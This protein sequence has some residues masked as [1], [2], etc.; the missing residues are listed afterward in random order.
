MGLFSK[1]K[2]NKEEKAQAKEENAARLAEFNPTLTIGIEESGVL[3]DGLAEHILVDEAQ[4]AFVVA[5]ASASDFR[6]NNPWIISFDQ[7][8]KAEMHIDEY[9]AENYRYGQRPMRGVGTLT[10]D[11]YKNVFWCYDYVLEMKTSHPYAKR[12]NCRFNGHTLGTKVPS[13]GIFVRR[14]LEVGCYANSSA[15]AREKAAAFDAKAEEEA[16]RNSRMKTFDLLTLQR[17]DT[18]MGR[19]VADGQNDFRVAIIQYA[20]FYLQEAAKFLEL[21]GK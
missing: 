3:G 12:L 18:L 17:P 20:S 11:Q 5:L 19:L 4:G 16:A 15:E 9:W 10:Q 7:V 2:E 1:L 13:K 6:A 14:G 8:E 21:L